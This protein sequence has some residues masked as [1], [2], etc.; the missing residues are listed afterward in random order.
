M[1]GAENL[2]TVNLVAAE[3]AMIQ[4]MTISANQLYLIAKLP[5][6]GEGIVEITVLR[7]GLEIYNFNFGN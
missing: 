7:P 5:Q 2:I 6:S 1:G 4:K 3:S